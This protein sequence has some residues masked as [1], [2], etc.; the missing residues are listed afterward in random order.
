M[1]KTL[2]KTKI[3]NKV[4]NINDNSF[5]M[6][7]KIIINNGIT[8]GISYFLYEFQNALCTVGVKLFLVLKLVVRL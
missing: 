4:I 6:N 2:Y 3:Y 1:I 7:N 8:N 5:D